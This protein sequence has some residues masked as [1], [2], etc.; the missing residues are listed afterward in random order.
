MYGVRRQGG[1]EGEREE[2]SERGRREGGRVGWLATLTK[3][4]AVQ[5]DSGREKSER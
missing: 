1:T 4:E 5:R 2:G 3:V